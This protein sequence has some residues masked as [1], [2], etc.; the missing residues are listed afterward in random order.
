MSALLIWM[1]GELVGTWSV[2]RTGNHRLDYAPSWRASAR[3]RALSLSLPFTADNRLEGD[4]VRNY[5]D[6][7]LPDSD[8]IRKRISARFHT[9]GTD[10]FTLLQAVGRDCVGAVQLLPSGVT[11]EGFDQ[12][13][14]EALTSGQIEKHLGALG[15]QVGVGAQDE[16]EGF[17]LCIAGAQEKTAL[18]QV[19][20]QWCRPLGA[21]PTTHILKP[22]IGV[23]PGRNLDLRLSVENEWLCNQIVRELGLPVAECQIQDFGARRVLVIKRFDRSWRPEGWIA[24]LPQEDFCQAKGVSSDQK[25][26]QKGGPSIEACLE[27][28]KGGEA[29]HEDGRNFLCA[30]LLFWYLAAIDGH[31]KNFSLFVLPGGRYRMTPLYDVLSAWPLIGTGPHSLQYKKTKLA[32]AVRSKTAHYKLSEIQYRHWE[33]LAKRSGVEGAW[34]A[35]LDM[36]HRLDTTLVA[37]EQRLPA[38]FPVELAHTVFQGVRRH[39]EQF[40]RGPVLADEATEAVEAKNVIGLNS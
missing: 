18:L 10:A 31:A 4:V 29:F 28:L 2:G 15:S 1:N 20:G 25:Y 23:T 9:K 5:F 33:A 24:R 39:L 13:R 12:L 34:D 8:G 22:P 16:E 27:V 38:D 37:V 14:Y 26:E 3:S 17:R 32:M 40:N 11:P 36:T 21:T 19:N 35:M 7:L 6:N 30:H